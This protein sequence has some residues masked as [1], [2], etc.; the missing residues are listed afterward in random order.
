MEVPV[1][2]FTMLDGARGEAKDEEVAGVGGERV[3]VRALLPRLRDRS[4][5]SGRRLLLVNIP[6]RLYASNMKNRYR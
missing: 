4:A 6:R 5:V 2:D 3:R 1:E